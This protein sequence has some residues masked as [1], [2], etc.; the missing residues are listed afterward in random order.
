MNRIE[1]I[2]LGIISLVG[3]AVAYSGYDLG[4]TQFGKPGAGLFPFILGIGLPLLCVPLLIR[5][6]RFPAARAA[7]P[8]TE[9]ANRPWRVESA[10]Y[11]ALIIYVLALPYLGFTICSL[12]LVFFLVRF[13]AGKS[14]ITSLMLS[15]ALVM[16]LVLILG[17]ALKVKLPEASLF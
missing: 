5:W 8:L 17:K 4:L 16:P 1:P 13:T 3:I 12:L 10:I 15:I 11:L 7:L 14:T 9:N 2:F 6:F